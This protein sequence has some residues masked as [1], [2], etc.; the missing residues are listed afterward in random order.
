MS[1]LISWVVFH[2][3]VV[4]SSGGVVVFCFFVVVFGLFSYFDVRFFAF[5]GIFVCWCVGS[6]FVLCV[7][8]FG[9]CWCGGVCFFVVV[10]LFFSF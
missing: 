10:V 5:F 7:F 6:F 3:G 2:S 8:V 9:F 1:G 4:F